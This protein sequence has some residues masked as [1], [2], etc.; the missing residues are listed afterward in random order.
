MCFCFAL[1]CFLTGLQPVGWSQYPEQV[2]D[3]GSWQWK[4]WVWTT[5]L[6]GQFLISRVWF[7]FFFGFS[8]YMT[9][10]SANKEF[11]F[12]ISNLYTFNIISYL[13]AL[14]KVF[15]CS[16]EKDTIVC[17]P[18]SSWWALQPFPGFAAV[19]RVPY[20]EHTAHVRTHALTSC[21]RVR[22][23]EPRTAGRGVW[24]SET[25]QAAFW[26][27]FLMS[28]MLVALLFW[29]S[30][31][32]L[33]SLTKNLRPL[34]PT[35]FLMLFIC[36]VFPFFFFCFLLKYFF[37]LLSYFTC[38]LTGYPLGE[39]SGVVQCRGSHSHP[40]LRCGKAFLGPGT[41][42]N[43]LQP[44]LHVREG[45]AGWAS[46]IEGIP[47]HLWAQAWGEGERGLP[48]PTTRCP[49]HFTS[50]IHRTHSHFAFIWGLGHGAFIQNLLKSCLLHCI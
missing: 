20:S 44:L 46:A 14:S 27:G 42:Q 39:V 43:F 50:G 37:I 26:A 15:E 3:S 25:C 23:A 28:S 19:S 10:P 8:T 2:S 47:S 24:W 5:E 6:P 29:I 33:C 21:R 16:V 38:Q 36:P 48:V 30:S 34:K 17:F 4:F 11:Y 31:D 40:S 18:L 1:F 13:I 35:V 32:T 41:L 12:F 22:R 49:A 45:R 7:F 9:I